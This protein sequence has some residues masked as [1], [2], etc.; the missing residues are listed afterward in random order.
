MKAKENVGKSIFCFYFYSSSMRL[1]RGWHFAVVWIIFLVDQSWKHLMLG[2]RPF[3]ATCMLV[4]IRVVWAS[5]VPNGSDVPNTRLSSHCPTPHCTNSCE[6]Y[7]RILNERDSRWMELVRR[8][9][10]RL[11]WRISRS[12]LIF[13]RQSSS[14]RGEQDVARNVANG[15][16]ECLEQGRRD[17]GWISCMS[18]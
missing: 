18:W 1:G 15:M 17:H 16:P 14:R 2:P 3:A 5:V 13:G 8:V 12:R 7:Q 4:R 11:P 10:H 6:N 9:H